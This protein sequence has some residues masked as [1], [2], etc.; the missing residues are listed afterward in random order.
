MDVKQIIEKYD[1]KLS[2]HQK[3]I[4]EKAGIE[5]FVLRKAGKEDKNDY[6]CVV[7]EGKDK[8][9]LGFHTD[10]FSV[11]QEWEKFMPSIKDSDK[12]PGNFDEFMEKIKQMSK[13][14]PGDNLG[15]DFEDVPRDFKFE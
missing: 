11:K 10:N 7:K 2:E 8:K 9:D 4:I 13:K 1:I 5:K 14:S 6:F 3:M 12:N 15:D